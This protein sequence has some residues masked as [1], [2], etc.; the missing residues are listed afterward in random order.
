[1]AQVVY[2]VANSIHLIYLF[3]IF[4]EVFTSVIGNLYGLERQ[5]RAYIRMNSIFTISLILICCYVISKIGYGTLIST[6]YP[7][8]AMS[9]SFYPLSLSKKCLPAR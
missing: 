8:L 7:V 1:M 3:V 2:Q 5:V 9:A 4:G 6:V